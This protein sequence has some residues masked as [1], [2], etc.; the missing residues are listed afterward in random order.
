MSLK[1][2][3]KQHHIERVKGKIGKQVKQLDAW[4]SAKGSGGIALN[5]TRDI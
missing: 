5:P 1:T 2:F 3:F 4:C